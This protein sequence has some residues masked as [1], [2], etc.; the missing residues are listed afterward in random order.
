MARLTSAQIAEALQR[1]GIPAD[2]PI[3]GLFYDH[4][5]GKVE[6]RMHGKVLTIRQAQ[7]PES[8]PA[9]PERVTLFPKPID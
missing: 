6:I 2:T 4:S 8:P 7:L 3:L 9:E 1:A 5:G